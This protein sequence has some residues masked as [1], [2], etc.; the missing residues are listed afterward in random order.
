VVIGVR[1]AVRALGGEGM[2][3]LKGIK[4]GIRLPLMLVAISVVALAIM[5]VSSYEVAR[6]IL[7][8]EGTDRLQQSLDTRVGTL[9]A[10]AAGLTSDLYATASNAGTARSLR[11]FSAA[12]DRLG[13][14]PQDDL[15]K[16]FIEA[17]PNPPAERYKLDY[18]G[19]VND[20]TILHRRY[21]PGFVAL[22]EQ[23]H[24]V[25]IYLVSVTGNVIYSLGKQDDFATN[26][27]E[28]PARGGPLAQIVEAAQQATGEAPVASGFLRDPGHPGTPGVVFLA[29]PLRSS[30]GLLLGVLV[31][32]ASA[33]PLSAV[34][35]DPRALGESGQGYVVGAGQTLE[36]TLRRTPAAGAPDLQTS[37]VRRALAGESGHVIE[38]G[39]DGAEVMAVFAP[40]TLFG[41]AYA[42]VVEQSTQELFE[43]ARAL[44]AR[45][46]LNGALLLVLLGGLSAWMARSVS[47]PLGRLTGTI[48]KIS[49]GVYDAEVRD[50]ERGDEIGDIARALTALR[51]DLAE[52]EVAR[53]VAAAQGTAFRA[54]S[55]AM[56]MVDAEFNI[57]YVNEAVVKMIGSRIEDF[58]QVTPEIDAEALVGKSMDMFHRN[59]TH[60]RAILRD[61]ANLPYRAEIV[62]GEGRFG[63]DIT[64]ITQPEKGRIGYVVEWR[65][66]T[67]LRMNRALLAAIDDYQLIF[68]FAPSGELTRVNRNLVTAL[69]VE[70]EALLG[71]PH[72]AVLEGVDGLE[73][74][75][76]RL[77]KHE[78]IV[79]RFRLTAPGGRS[80]LAEGSV[81][82]VPDRNDRLLK[83]VLIANDVTEAQAELQLEHERNE[84]MQAG[85]K[86]VV[87]GLRVALQ[88][89]ATGDLC[90]LLD[91]EF[92]PEYE[93]LRQDF[94]RAV[95][96]L[97]QAVQVVIDN[98]AEIDGE[99]REISNAAEDLSSRTERQAA[100]LE[101]TAAALD[102]LTSSVS[103][104][105]AGVGEANMVVVQAR[106]SAE[107]SGQIV[108]QAVAAMGE[109]EE[110]SRK[111]SRI[112]GVIDDIA[113]QTNLLALN[114]G[115]E[116]ARAGEAGRGFAVV[117]SEVR[118]LAQRSSEAA[119]EIDTLITASSNH[120]R[121][122]VDLVGE[123]GS[124]L[125]RILGSVNDIAARVSEIAASAQEQSAGL[126]EINT[127][128]NQ[129]DQV[130]QHNAAM[131][132]QTTAASHALTRGAQALT[133]TTAQFRTAGG[134]AK[135]APAAAQPIDLA[136]HKASVARA[137][138]ATAQ[139]AVAIEEEDWEDF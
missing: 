79:G 78:P 64:E 28:G 125:Q 77:E 70:A 83:I 37:A 7:T 52:A 80:L 122:G 50:G 93:Q 48:G 66:V 102:Q 13:E 6:K 137:A 89:L 131:F 29:R 121:R 56:M 133:V 123:T 120:V 15:R 8:S 45:L 3:V 47:K 23:K 129:L 59:P 111:I 96:T 110:S 5:G 103:S 97:S 132:E 117:A 51:D 22:A 20:Y 109:I 128:M 61:S 74:F 106:E 75:W 71:L 14:R 10:W 21:H 94:N 100:T 35:A 49:E 112:I 46:T 36:S 139:A 118:A 11:E 127:A 43:P 87:E 18:P 55:A 33:D 85:Q 32:E 38:A 101:E 86:Q 84:A 60:A 65:D 19:E 12:W 26:L 107:S 53:R 104:A 41:K 42:A 138:A 40:F 116:A 98:A 39:V 114:A 135:P 91:A 130:T 124:A 69:G 67:E 134:T 24:L 72:E 25:D 82:P 58:R 34:M 57:R 62:V 76:P 95:T 27:R 126:A 105:A 16:A 4:L 136:R 9:E 90:S 81:T 17:N 88:R 63:L 99:A 115:V 44:A 113:F 54:S 108:Q 2:K 92:P 73:G 68:E 119:R 31:F 30:E 1:K